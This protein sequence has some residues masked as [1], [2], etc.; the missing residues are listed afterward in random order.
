MNKI[1][2][3]LLVVFLGVNTWAFSQCCPYITSVEV[4][5]QNPDTSD[6]IRIAT[7]IATPNNGEFIHHQFHWQNDTLV[8][9]ACYY[10]GLLTVVTPI[11][12]TVDIGQVPAG[13]YV[14]RF[15]ASTSIYQDSCVANDSQT[16]ISSFSVSE[17]VGLKPI[18]SEVSLLYPNPSKEFVKL[19]RVEE[20]SITSVYS[21]EGKKIDVPQYKTGNEV[22][23]DIRS[24]SKG[25]YEVLSVFEGRI[26]YRYR[27]MKE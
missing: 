13:D 10:S 25:M 12:D 20:G 7:L 6:E 21:A 1:G 19:T 9:E 24:I 16:Q 14:L 27:F 3:Q 5:P 15:V 23:L 26:P 18:T 8:V 4:L 22:V 2:L 17:M 11:Y